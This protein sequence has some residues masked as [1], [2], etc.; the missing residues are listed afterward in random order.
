M[1]DVELAEPLEFE[2][3]VVTRNPKSTNARNGYRTLGMLKEGFPGRLFELETHEDEHT[4]IERIAELLRDGDVVAPF[5]GDSTATQAAEAISRRQDLGKVP[6]APF[7]LGNANQIA[8][9]LNS[10]LR[11]RFP[12]SL[13][14]RGRILP[15]YPFLFRA[16]GWSEDEAR[17]ALFTIGIGVTGAS[18]LGLDSPEFR[19]NRLNRL[20]F[21]KKIPEAQVAVRGFRESEPFRK[22]GLD[23]IEVLLVNGRRVAKHGRFDIE[24]PEQAFALLELPDK[25]PTTLAPVL[26]RFAMQLTQPAQRMTN[27]TLEFTVEAIGDG[28]IMGQNDGQPFVVKP[29]KVSI[30][31]SQRP[32]YVVTTRRSLIQRG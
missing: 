26:I 1:E 16:Q 31:R 20:P 9:M 7:P 6:L 22:D 5:G 13:L 10:W 15:I 12:V 27:E 18:A 21:L 30:T 11:Y 19:K 14:Q 23:R 29:G 3:L 24:L 28:P 17:L 4:N 2:R 25:R 8:L 32:I